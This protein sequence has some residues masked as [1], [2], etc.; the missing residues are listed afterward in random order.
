MDTTIYTA[1]RPKNILIIIFFTAMI[2]AVLFMGLPAL[3]RIADRE[4]ETVTETQYMLAARETPKPVEKRKEK[5]L[6]QK[7]L[8]QIPKPKIAPVSQQ[9]MDTPK[10]SFDLN[11]TGVEGIEVAAIPTEG[12]E[13][14]MDDFAFSLKDVDAPPRATRTPPALYPFSARTK[15]LEGRVFVHIRIGI[16]GKATNIKAVKAEPPEVLEVFGEAA[17]KAVTK[18][19]FEPA[20]LGGEA[21]PVWANQPINFNLD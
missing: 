6:R 19:R 7:E 9:K 16:D 3:T 21:V 5:I 18:Y 1:W 4:R 10:F 12:M 17:E 14:K 15:G 13:I 2:N 8:K 11:G 20:I